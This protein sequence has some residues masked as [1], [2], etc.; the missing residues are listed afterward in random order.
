MIKEPRV[1]L[2]DLIECLSKA[3]DL[4]CPALVNHHERVA[5]IA[6]CIGAELG[7]PPERL[8]ELVL[9]GALHDSGALSLR[10][11]LD[12]LRFD[13]EDPFE[14]AEL[15]YLLLAGFEPLVP[16]ARLVRY[17]HVTWDSRTAV[18]EAA[19]EDVPFGSHILFLADRVA[20]LLRDGEDVLGQARGIREKIAERSGSLF[21]PELVDVFRFLAEKEYFWLDA[22]STSPGAV[23]RSMVGMETTEL[24]L[25]G[26]LDL[27]N[28]F[29]Q[30]IDFRS[31]FTATHSVGVAVSAEA[32]ALEAGFSDRERLMMRVAGHLHDLGKLA[33][34]VDVLEKPGRLTGWERGIIRSH[35]FHTYRILEPIHDLETINAWG[36]FHHERI[37]GTG[38][39]FHHRGED[40]SLGSRIMAVA[41]VFTAVT[42]DRPYRVGMSK[43]KTLRVLQ[44]MA[45]GGGLDRSVVRMLEHRYD[46]INAVRIAA[47][48]A[49]GD[50]YQRFLPA[51]PQRHA[52]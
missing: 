38:Y 21:S 39:P 51:S 40:L 11:R 18:S 29:R 20:V 5:Y 52:G 23:L 13:A 31:R 8:R 50:E 32:L 46:D 41:D 26:L 37:D 47:Q 35:T 25:H 45:A 33:V 27:S 44:G 42:E 34:P 17:H 10:E 14:H 3:M 4:V 19:G 15:G 49:A 24:S 6:F 22:T 16:V 36:A 9:A 7:L 48:K 12:A 2:F 1:Q 28:L 43:E 30:I